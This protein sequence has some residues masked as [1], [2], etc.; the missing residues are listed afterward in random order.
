MNDSRYTVLLVEDE[1]DDAILMRRAFQ[2]AN[3][4][5]PLQ[6]VH[7]GEEAISYLSGQS[8]FADRDRFPLPSLIL[9]D[10]KLPRKSGLEVL[11]WIRSRPTGL[12]R[13]NVIVFSSSSQSADVN[14]AYELGA[15][16][17][18]VKPLD[19]D[20]LLDL[21]KTLDLY[22]LILNEAP[23]VCGEYSRTEVHLL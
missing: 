13:L 6:I 11:G 3:V 10:L 18:I 21:V 5:I 16:S 17:Y 14:R 1:P 4:G 20:R 23:E 12:R 8:E 22:W 9:L 2:K 7:D 19:F 15:N